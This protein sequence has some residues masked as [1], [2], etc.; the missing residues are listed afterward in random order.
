MGLSGCIPQDAL[1]AAVEVDMGWILGA[2]AGAAVP[3]EVRMRRVHDQQPPH[4]KGR[5]AKHRPLRLWLSPW[6][7]RALIVATVSQAEINGPCE[8]A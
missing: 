6:D 5:L 2:L 1:A 4:A 3:R 8:C 7:V